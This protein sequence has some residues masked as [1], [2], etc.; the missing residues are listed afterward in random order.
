MVRSPPVD[1]M[2]SLPCHVT[3]QPASGAA[4]QSRFRLLCPPSGSD[5]QP[6]PGDKIQTMGKKH[7]K[8]KSEKH[9][10]EGTSTEGSSKE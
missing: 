9:G 10:F 6:V 4:G 3:A 8:H 1:N 2:S 5:Q 7:K